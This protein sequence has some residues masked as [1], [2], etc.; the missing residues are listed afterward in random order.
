MIGNITLLM[1]IIAI[2]QKVHLCSRET[3]GGRHLTDKGRGRERGDG[4]CFGAVGD[5]GPSA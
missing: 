5:P 4:V 3:T 2:A 1:E